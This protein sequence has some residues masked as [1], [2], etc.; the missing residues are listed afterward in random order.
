M[1]G[2]MVGVGGDVMGDVVVEVGE[3]EG[4][5]KEVSGG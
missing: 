4:W 5:G 2:G 1:G 3:R